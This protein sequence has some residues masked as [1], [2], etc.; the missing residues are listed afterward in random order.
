VRDGALS[1]FPGVGRIISGVGDNRKE[2]IYV[3]FSLI[4]KGETC[5]LNESLKGFEKFD[6]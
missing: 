1:C 3:Y 4:T 2:V 5:V 6:G